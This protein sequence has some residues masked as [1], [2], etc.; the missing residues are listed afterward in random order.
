MAHLPNL[1]DNELLRLAHIELD[2]L[3]STE[4]ERELLRR[5]EDNA[6]IT[7]ENEPLLQALADHE[8]GTDDPAE[9][10]KLLDEHAKVSEFVHAV[11]MLE[12]LSEF[13][14]DNPA[15]LKKVL[16]RDAKFENV[17]NDLAEPLASLQALA[18]TE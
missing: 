6:A 17:M 13:D 12:V 4:L 18:T 14:F 10:T 5:F 16:E 3:T 1:D 9:L 11:A 15:A 7:A 8:H 2:P